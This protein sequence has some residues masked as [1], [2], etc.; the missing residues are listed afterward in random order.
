MAE[1]D[2]L[3]HGAGGRLL[4]IDDD[5][6]IRFLARERLGCQGF[7]VVEAGSGAEGIEAIDRLRPDVIL[8][9]V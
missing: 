9:D 3:K 5:P 2:Q 4:I 8:L 1:S 6:L 7:E